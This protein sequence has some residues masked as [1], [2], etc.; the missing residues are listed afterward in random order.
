MHYH[1]YTLAALSLPSHPSTTAPPPLH[2]LYHH[3]STTYYHYIPHH[4]IPITT[5]PFHHFLSDYP[6]HGEADVLPY[7]LNQSIHI[8][9]WCLQ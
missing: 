5:V 2:H 9:S 8:F 3:S 6:S 7:Q 1:S 4:I